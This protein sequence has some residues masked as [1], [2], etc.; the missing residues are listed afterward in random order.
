MAEL[1]RRATGAV[2]AVRRQ[3]KTGGEADPELSLICEK[4]GATIREVLDQATML[5]NHGTIVAGDLVQRRTD[6][7]F[8]RLSA[9]LT[10]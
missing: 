8:A 10:A 5:V 9:A 6:A 3:F 4:A 1:D 2:A 7:L